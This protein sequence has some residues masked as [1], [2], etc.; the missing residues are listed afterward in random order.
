MYSVPGMFHGT[1]IQTE[2][3]QVISSAYGDVDTSE[4]RDHTYYGILQ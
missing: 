2:T 1:K 3:D 4:I